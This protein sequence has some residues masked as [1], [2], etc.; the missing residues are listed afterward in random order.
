MPSPFGTSSLVL[1]PALNFLGQ[2]RSKERMLRW[3]PGAVREKPK[4]GGDST[5]TLGFPSRPL[6]SKKLIVHNSGSIMVKAQNNLHTRN[7]A[8]DAVVLEPGP[9]GSGWLEK[10][11]R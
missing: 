1:K 11:G 10:L 9:L 8:V 4:G 2:G 7:A 3:L 6:Q 5:A